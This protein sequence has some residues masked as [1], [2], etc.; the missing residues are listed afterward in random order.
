[1]RT[2][3]TLE[4]MRDLAERFY[5]GFLAG[6]TDALTDLLAPEAVLVVGIDS[7]LGRAHRGPAGIAAFRA[8]IAEVSGGTWRPLRDDSYD[9]ATSEW[10]AVVLDRYLAQRGGAQLDS[11]ETFVLAVEDGRIARLFH[12]AHEPN[13]FARF[14]R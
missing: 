4:Q 1:M 5:R 14:W 6:D 12:Y 11:H 13:A 3:E 10:H 9:I 8:R 7:S 2:V